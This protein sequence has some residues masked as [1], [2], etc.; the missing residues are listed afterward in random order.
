VT[1]ARVVFIVLFAI[2]MATVMEAGA[3]AWAQKKGGY[4]L[5][6]AGGYLNSTA[7]I[8]ATGSRI[9]KAGLGELRDLNYSLYL[10]YGVLDRLNP[11]C[12]S[13]VQATEGY[14]DLC[15]GKSL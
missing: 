1:R 13:S 8:D 12:I 7:D 2:Q 9:K 3:G 4:Y 6:L 5:K 14:A 11:G 15:H 10:E